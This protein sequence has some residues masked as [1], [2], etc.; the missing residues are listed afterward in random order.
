M[1]YAEMTLSKF[2]SNLW[3][4]R[5][6]IPF[7]LPFTILLANASISVDFPDPEGPNTAMISPQVAS[8]DIL[9]SRT[10]VF[11]YSLAADWFLVLTLEKV[12]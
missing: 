11:E 1:T 9:L 4:L 10:F 3:P 12:F 8:P 7:K 5:F 2:E 6:I